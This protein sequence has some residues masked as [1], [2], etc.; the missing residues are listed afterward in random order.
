MVKQSYHEEMFRR[1]NPEIGNVK[2]AIEMGAFDDKIIDRA[3]LNNQVIIT[4]DIGLAL[5]AHSRCES[6]VLR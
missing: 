4:K 2:N 5:R 3:M 1:K 6:L